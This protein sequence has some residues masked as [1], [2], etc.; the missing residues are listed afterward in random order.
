MAKKILII[1]DEKDIM[2]VV[3]IRLKSAGYEIIPP[4]TAE[5]RLAWLENNKPDLI[6]LN[7]LLPKMQGKEFCQKQKS[8][9]KFKKIPIVLFTATMIASEQLKEFGADDCIFKPYESQEILGKVKKF[10]G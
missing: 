2:D 6:L 5:E 3:T 4:F 7:V 9:N 10:I 1:E 8:D